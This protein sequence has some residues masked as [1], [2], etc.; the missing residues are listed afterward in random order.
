MICRMNTV[1]TATWCSKKNQNRGTMT[2]EQ[3]GKLHDAVSRCCPI[4]KLMTTSDIVFE[5]AP[6]DPPVTPKVAG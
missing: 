5:A 3:R 1:E 6:L 4:P 2:D